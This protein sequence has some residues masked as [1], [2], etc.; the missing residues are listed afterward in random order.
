[1]RMESLG[2]LG[3]DSFHF[4]V[5]NLER[6]RLFY[7]ERFDFDEVARAGPA[8]VEKSG[9]VSAVFGAGDVRVC[10]STPLHEDCKAARYLRRHPAG[11][12]SLSF[13]VEDLDRTY[14][15][16]DQRGAA[17][18]ADPIE[19]RTSSGGRYR[20][21]EIATP[22]GD[23][24]FRYV[25]RNDYRHF[26]PGFEQR[27][28]RPKPNRFGIERVD[29]VTSNA[30]T[31]Q[32]LILFYREVLGMEEFWNIRFHTS[33]LAREARAKRGADELPAPRGGALAGTGLRSI[34]MWDPEGDI[35]FAS[36]EPL[37]P[38][39]RE[40]Q[41]ARFCY[42]NAGPGIQ[43]LAFRLPD[44]VSA[45]T[46]LGARGVPFLPTH[47]NYYRLLPERLAKLKIR[48]VSHDLAALEKLEILVD[49]ENDKYMLQIFLR[50]AATLYGDDRAGPFFYE[51]IERCGDEGFGYG[52]FRA[53]FEAIEH[54]QEPHTHSNAPPG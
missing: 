14:K 15:L 29:H 51:L 22:L 23:V 19:D 12:M 2:I 41:I 50:E 28:E 35:K 44:I 16:L 26:A 24:A 7:T 49:G 11:I 54:A 20:A 46:E 47:K 8:L 13:R 3:F 42:D 48:N 17:F 52:N 43:H 37:K 1:M 39:F 6:S 45:V 36:N 31:M 21:F 34:V 25:E 53:L 4:A 32:P 5:E 33:D 38:Y 30:L 40:S 9:Q 18:L 10:V 27:V